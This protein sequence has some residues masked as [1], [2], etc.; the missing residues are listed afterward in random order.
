MSLK[1]TEPNVLQS[2]TIPRG[3]GM[4]RSTFGFTRSKFKV[5]RCRN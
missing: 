2:G 1:T 4:K 3:E 5:T